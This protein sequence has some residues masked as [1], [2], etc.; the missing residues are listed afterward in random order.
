MAL[1]GLYEKMGAWEDAKR[2][3]EQSHSLD[4]G[5]PYIANNLAYLY[6]EHDGDAHMALSLAQQAQQKLPDSPIVADTIGWAYYTLG[7]AEAAVAPLSESVRRA[8]SNATY[9]YHLG[10]AY[11][12]AGHHGDAARSL[13]QA[14]ACNPDFPYAE[15]A[16]TALQSISKLAP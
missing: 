13:R 8:P 16:R 14:L 1:S 3:A 6:L 9:R 10:M 11:L 12:A 7:L 15:S 5:S 2:A 4:P